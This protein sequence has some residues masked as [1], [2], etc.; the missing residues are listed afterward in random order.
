MTCTR[1][2]LVTQSVNSLPAIQE[3]WVGFLGREDFPWRRKWQPTPVFLPGE[4]HGQRSLAGYNPWG[5]KSRTQLSE[6][7]HSI[8]TCSSWNISWFCYP[9]PPGLFLL[10][11]FVCF[12]LGQAMQ[13]VGSWA[14]D[15]GSNPCPLHWG[16]EVLTTVPPGKSPS[17]PT[18]HKNHAD[19][20][21]CYALAAT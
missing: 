8:M 15:Q 9:S 19:L 13:H 12:F 5:H 16:H 17:P 10:L 14:S 18:N 7:A 11:F 4:S 2:S 21:F 1:A 6:E 20:V 3:T